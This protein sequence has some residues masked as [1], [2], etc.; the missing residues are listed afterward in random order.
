MSYAKTALLLAAMTALFLMAGWLIGGE[1]GA[2]IAFFVALAM[3]GYAWWSSD[4][5]ALRMHNAREVDARTAPQLVEMVRELSQR[6]ELPMP[7]VYIIDD[8]QP[9]AFAT[10]RSPDNAAVAATTGILQSLTREELAGVMAHELAH[11]K[12]RDTLIMTVTATISGAIGFLANM[13][14]FSLIFGGDRSRS[15]LGLIGVL[16]AMILAPL[17]ALVVQMAISRTREYAAD[18]MGGEIC[19]N[20]LWLAS[21]LAKIAQ[22]VQ[23]REMISAERHPETAHLFIMNPLSGRRFDGL[24]TTHPDPRNRIEALQAQARGMGLA[25][26]GPGADPIS[27]DVKPAARRSGAP[28][29]PSRIPSTRRRTPWS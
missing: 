3:N 24:F 13:A 27:R 17:A 14:Q 7:R 9:N 25:S 5:L 10:G 29:R 2:V 26:E 11:I 21:A 1:G 28:L 15:P 22:L 8:P 19:G 12:N 16:L 6:A 20:P 18:K 23:G 4:S